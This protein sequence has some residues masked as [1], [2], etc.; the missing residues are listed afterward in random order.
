[1]SILL[2]D[3]KNN[4]DNGWNDLTSWRLTL[5]QTL[6]SWTWSLSKKSNSGITGVNG[7]EGEISEELPGIYSALF[8]T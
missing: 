2:C 6:V 5:S 7:S 4:V 1:M 3:G 8:V